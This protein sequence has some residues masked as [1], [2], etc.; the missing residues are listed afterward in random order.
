MRSKQAQKMV[1]RIIDSAADAI[2]A[3]MFNP[4]PERP[5]GYLGWGAICLGAASV[6]IRISYNDCKTAVALSKQLNE[7]PVKNRSE[8]QLESAYIGIINK[9]RLLGKE[10]AGHVARAAARLSFIYE[11]VKKAPAPGRK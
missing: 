8:K 10:L 4:S 9:R 1:D 6:G 3:P 5:E 7:E 2:G 11:P